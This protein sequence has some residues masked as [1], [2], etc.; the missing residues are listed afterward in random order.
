MILLLYWSW[1]VLRA[2]N[3]INTR[4]QNSD[5]DYAT[6]CKLYQAGDILVLICSEVT[7]YD[8]MEF[9]NTGCRIILTHNS[10]HD[11]PSLLYFG[12][13]DWLNKG[14]ELINN[15]VLSSPDLCLS[16]KINLCCLGHAR[17]APPYLI[18]QQIKWQHGS[19]HHKPHPL[20]KAI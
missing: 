10:A 20:Q 4:L 5:Y 13:D 14:W 16:N 9:H 12:Q 7:C 1:S 18:Y 15:H 6:S 2:K 11:Q 3:Y 19:T 8:D 17:N